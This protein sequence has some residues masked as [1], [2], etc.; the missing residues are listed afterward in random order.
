MLLWTPILDPRSSGSLTVNFSCGA[1]KDISVWLAG[2]CWVLLTSCFNASTLQQRWDVIWRESIG[3]WT[4]DPSSG[5]NKFSNVFPTNL[6]QKKEPP[7]DWLLVSPGQC[8][9]GLLVRV[10]KL[11]L[12]PWS[13]PD[14]L[15][16]CF[17][18]DFHNKWRQILFH[19]VFC[20]A[21]HDKWSQTFQDDSPW[22]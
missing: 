6:N 21:F 2:S 7:L 5:T 19:F 8:V 11:D 13:L 22:L 4:G 3:A 12:L 14:S 1:G 15:P 9:S 18:L 10:L 17:C 16:L 20:L